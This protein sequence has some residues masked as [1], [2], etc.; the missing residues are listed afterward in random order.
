MP[1]MKVSLG[2]IGTNINDLDRSNKSKLKQQKN[3]KLTIRTANRFQLGKK[4]ERNNTKNIPKFLT[5]L[6]GQFQNY[7]KVLS[8]IV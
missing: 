4:E 2:I 6:R 7:I 5:L 8:S 1:G 3:T